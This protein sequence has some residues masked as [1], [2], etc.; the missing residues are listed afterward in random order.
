MKYDVIIADDLDQ[1]VELLAEA[2]KTSDRFNVVFKAFDGKEVIEYLS[3][4]APFDDRKLFPLPQL[5]FLDLRM[6][7]VDGFQVLR[8]IKEHRA[9][10][11]AMIVTSFANPESANKATDLGAAAVFNKPLS[12]EDTLSVI[13]IANAHFAKSEER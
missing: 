9:P 12:P 6:L 2:L 11:L 1:H 7:Q 3:G 4:R 10:V 5:L 13:Q 8:W